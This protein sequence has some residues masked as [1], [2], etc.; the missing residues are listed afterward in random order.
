VSSAPSPLPDLSGDYVEHSRDND[1]GPQQTRYAIRQHG[2]RVTLDIEEATVG[3]FLDAGSYAGAIEKVYEDRPLVRVRLDD[4]TRR[5]FDLQVRLLVNA[6]LLHLVVAA[7]SIAFH[8][9]PALRNV[10]AVLNRMAAV[11]D[12]GPFLDPECYAESD[13]RVP[14]RE[15][16]TAAT[17][18]DFVL[19]PAE[20]WHYRLT[21]HC[22]DH[23]RSVLLLALDGLLDRQ[24]VWFN[25]LG[26]AAVFGAVCL[27]EHHAAVARVVQDH[28][29]EARAT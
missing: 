15:T 17:W 13:L 20:S 10:I 2:A 18:C 5:Y 19:G 14:H 9:E 1:M 25:H 8:D 3:S 28:V 26:H 4:G 11:F 27:P 6:E 29:P 23:G 22:G 7:P 12:P 24:S 21:L 16:L